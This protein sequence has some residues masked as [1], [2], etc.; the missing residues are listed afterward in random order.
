VLS[1]IRAPK[2]LYDSAQG[3]NPGNRISPAK[4]PEG[5]PGRT[6]NATYQSVPISR[7]FSLSADLIKAL[8]RRMY[9]TFTHRSARIILALME[10]KP[11]AISRD[12][13]RRR[14]MHFIL[15][16]VGTNE[17]PAS[18]KILS[19]KPGCLDIR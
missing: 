5:A 19:P 9:K 15:A 14:K 16:D 2:G 10:L 6:P 17:P 13:P 18:L 1:A 8:A 4:S 3:F 12:P 7:P 11:Q